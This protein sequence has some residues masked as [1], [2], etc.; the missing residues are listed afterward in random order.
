MPK[1][2]FPEASNEYI[3]EVVKNL[4]AKNIC[5]A[6][7]KEMPVEQ[8]AEKVKTG[9]YDAMV[10]GVDYSSRDVILACRLS[11]IDGADQHGSSSD[12]WEQQ[13]V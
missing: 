11:V 1:I 8:A 5:E 10:A 6:I 3:Q 2:I 7:A 9:E 4:N 13:A 12:R